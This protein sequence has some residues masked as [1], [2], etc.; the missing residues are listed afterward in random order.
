M[1]FSGTQRVVFNAFK[2]AL[3]TGEISNVNYDGHINTY[4]TDCNFFFFYIANNNL[5]TTFNSFINLYTTNNIN[6]I[7]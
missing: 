5:N 3:G 2:Y 6:C 7:K 4:I 1:S